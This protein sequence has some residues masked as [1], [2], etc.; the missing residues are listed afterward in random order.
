[1][2][3]WN[4]VV[5][6]RH[7][8]GKALAALGELG[9]V[10]RTGLYNVIAMRVPDV[11][12]LLDR[13]AQLPDRERVLAPIGHLVPVTH[14]LRFTSTEDLERQAREIVLAWAPALTGKSVH[15]VVHWRGRKVDLHAHE[16]EQRLAEALLDEVERIGTPARIALTNADAVI[17][18]ETLRDEAGLA[19]WTRG[20]LD[21]YPFL[22]ASLDPHLAHAAARASVPA[23]A[24]EIGS[25]LGEVQ[26]WTIERLLATR[27]TLDEISAA[28]SAIEDE[29]GFG[30][31]HHAPS[32]PREAEVRAILEEQVFE[33]FEERESELART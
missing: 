21:R 14:K 12:A 11:C 15:V 4:V 27:A 17:V 13:I 19:L 8:F 33:D 10:E 3:S 31:S 6:V 2:K 25:V 16:L 32:T 23:T 30:E 1:M 24:A 20:E 29:I 7:D 9:T 26:P 22:R 18:L 28:I 5:T